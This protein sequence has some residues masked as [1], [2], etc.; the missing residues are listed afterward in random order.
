MAGW[1]NQQDENALLVA[2]NK[3]KQKPKKFVYVKK[4]GKGEGF[5]APGFKTANPD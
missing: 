1:T 2:Q 3:E 5:L 4:Q